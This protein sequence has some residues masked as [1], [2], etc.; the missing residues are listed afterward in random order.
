MLDEKRTDNVAVMMYTILCKNAPTHLSSKFSYKEHKYDLRQG[1][2]CVNVV[3][4]KSEALKRSFM[5]KGATIWNE[6]PRHVKLSPNL[7]SFKR[8]LMRR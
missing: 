7:L 4:P 2:Q 5:Y 8:E 1:E 3:R 6:L